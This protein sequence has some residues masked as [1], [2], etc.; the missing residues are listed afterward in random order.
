MGNQM[1]SLQSKFIN[2]FVGLDGKKF[3]VIFKKEVANMPNEGIT[4]IVIVFIG[5]I[6]FL[7]KQRRE[8]KRLKKQRDVMQ[9]FNE[10]LAAEVARSEM[11][12]DQAVRNLLLRIINL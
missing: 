12:L 2:Y 6:F 1:I 7:R 5:G 10:F 3:K 11:I 9:D 4:A 8:I